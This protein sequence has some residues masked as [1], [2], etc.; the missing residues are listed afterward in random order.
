[1]AEIAKAYVQIIPSAQGISGGIEKA[2]GGEAEKAG[3]SSGKKFGASF[4]GALGTAGKIAAGAVAAGTAAVTAFAKSSVDA[5]AQFDASMSQVAAT[6]GLTVDEIGNLRDFA[7]EMGS[8]TAFSATEAADALNYMALAGYDAQTSMEMLPNVLNLAAAGGME[9]ATA[10]DMITDSQSALGLTLEE[11]S[12]LVDQM[13]KASSKSNTSVSQLGEA[14]LKIGGT[15]KTL[16]GGTTELATALGI[17][18]DNG[19]KGAEG[20]TALRNIMLT[21]QAPTDKAAKAMDYLG[22]SAFDAEGNMRPLQEI[23][24]DFNDVLADASDAERTNILNDIFNKVDLKNVNA[25]MDTNVERWEELSSAIDDSS[26]AAQQMAETQLDNLTGDI[27]L[28]Q[29]ALEGAKIAISDNLTPSLREF[30]SFGTDGLSRITEAF[31]T[32]GMTGAMTELGTVLS[33]GISMIAQKAP[34]M[35]NAGMQLLSALGEGIMSNIGPITDAMMQVVQSIVEKLLEPGTLQSVLQAGLNII[36]Q[37]A[38]GISQALPTLIPM[39][40]E[41]MLELVNTLIE[42]IPMLVDAAVQ[43]ITGLADGIIQA[44]PILIGALPQIITGLVDAIIA[45]LPTLIQGII[46]LVMMIV[47]NFPTII[48]S[49]I[50][51]IPEIITAIV[52]ALPQSL[53][54]LIEGAVQL[55]VALA[56][57]WP[58]ICY[59]LFEAIPDIIASIVLAFADLGPQLIT[60]LG[61]AFASLGPTF[62]QLATYAQE[63]WGDIKTAFSPAANWFSNTFKSAGNAVKNAWKSITQFFDGIWKDIV[64]VFSNANAKFMDIGRNI[65]DGIKQGIAGTWDAFKSWLSNLFG[66]L[67]ALAKKILGIASPSKVFA[68][69]VG[70]WIPAGIAEGIQSGMGVLNDEIKKMTDKAL[71]GTIQESNEIVNSV[72]YIPDASSIQ[73][74]N[75]VV[76]NNNIQVDGAT[77]PEAWTQTFISTLKREA[78]MA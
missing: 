74:G 7:Q 30:V 68:K 26:G 49:L 27:T 45:A 51:A 20:G 52:M 23:F 72:N 28:F 9:L 32:G 58:E 73:T 43:I 67:V 14:I 6:M 50:E 59:A 54:A 21:L 39:A 61:N 53:P 48:Q 65:V 70:Q 37:L 2:L 33:E 12:T 75:S 24:A 19:T 25:L 60:E 29:S 22:I 76:I 10:S 41:V 44:L 36:T 62:E 3:V 78:R 31:Q 42:N 69:Q 8:S 47:Q 1:M 77:D 66:D 71:L 17:L 13:A 11:T 57:A 4:A 18:A 5:G 38:N 15:A 55:I 35:I 64:D 46:Q 40:V 34:E 16:S 63:A 56:A